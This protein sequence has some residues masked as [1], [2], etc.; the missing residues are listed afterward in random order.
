MHGGSV[1]ASSAG[2]GKGSTFTVRF[3]AILTGTL[4]PPSS[5]S[6]EPNAPSL[7]E[8]QRATAA[9]RLD[10]VRVLVVEDDKATLEMLRF[11]LADAG[12][13][14]IPASSPREALQ[15]LDRRLPH[16]LISDLAMP[17]EDGF[18]LIARVRGRPPERGGKIPAVALSAYARPEDSARARAAG[19]QLHLCK[20]IDPDALVDVVAELAGK[21]QS[22]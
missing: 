11:A 1:A 22:H 4:A 7:N 10:G 18:D 3:P 12:A 8:R 21:L 16:V 9:S 19:F 20:P 2:K 15:T 5:R 6:S 17:G 13:E 14:V